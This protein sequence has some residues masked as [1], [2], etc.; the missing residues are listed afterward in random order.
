[1]ECYFIITFISFPL[2]SRLYRVCHLRRKAVS[3]LWLGLLHRSSASVCRAYS[4]A[5]CGTIPELSNILLLFVRHLADKKIA[6][7]KKMLPPVR[8]D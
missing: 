7:E 8:V 6:N 1:M 4:R 2:D 3:A 5:E